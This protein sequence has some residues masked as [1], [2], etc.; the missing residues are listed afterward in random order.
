MKKIEFSDHQ[1]ADI[2]GNIDCGFI[3]YYSIKTNVFINLIE[4]YDPMATGIDESEFGKDDIDENPD[5]YIEFRQ[6]NSN[7]SFKVMSDF[8]ENDSDVQFQKRL[9]QALNNP[10]PFRNFKWII[11]NSGDYRQKWFDYKDLRNKEWVLEQLDAHN[12]Q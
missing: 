7:Q 3:C 2:A 1:I 12:L 10:K 4:N 5:D 8:A 6:M 9:F 11:D